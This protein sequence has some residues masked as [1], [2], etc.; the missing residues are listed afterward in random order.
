M[1]MGSEVAGWHT[2]FLNMRVNRSTLTVF[3]PDG[4]KKDTSPDSERVTVYV[5]ASMKR[6]PSPMYRGTSMVTLSLFAKAP[7]RSSADFN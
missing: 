3:V 7:S 2:Q 6:P 4:S 1:E 5:V